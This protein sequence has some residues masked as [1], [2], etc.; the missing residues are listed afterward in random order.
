[1][2]SVSYAPDLKTVRTMKVNDATLPTERR[3]GVNLADFD[4]VI[5]QVLLKNSCTA[6]TVT[7]HYWS[8]EKGG[9]VADAVGVTVV[10]AAVGIRKIVR[11]GRCESVFFEVTA[12]VGGAA[13][14]DRV[15][16]ELSG[17]PSYDK[18]G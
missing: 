5:V 1:M 11:V 13:S 3:A 12:I 4:E 16:I 17:I 18:V 15:F 10:A 14:A 6:A 8:P 9:F 7:P 2:I